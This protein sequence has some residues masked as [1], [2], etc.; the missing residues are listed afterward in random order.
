[1]TK[2]EVELLFWKGKQY[3]KFLLI[4][5]QDIRAGFCALIVYALNGIRK[6]E[7]INAIPIIDFNGNNTAEYYEE[8]VGTSIWDYFFESTVPF[9]PAQIKARLKNGELSKYAV[10][11]IPANEFGFAHHHDPNRIATFWSWQEP[12]DRANWMREKRQLGRL[13][14]QKYVHPKE[15]ITALVDHFVQANF[16]GSFIIGL[17]IRGTDFDYAKPITID[18]YNNEI[19]RLVRKHNSENYKIY[20]A[21]DQQQY[22]NQF[23]ERYGKK[24]IFFEVTRSSSHIA[25][26]RLAGVSGYR[27][28]ED[29][30]IDILLLSRCRHIIKG[31]AALGEMGLW[32]CDHNNITDFAVQSKFYEKRY[33][34][35]RSAFSALNIGQISHGQLK[36]QAFKEGVIKHLLALKIIKLMFGKFERVRRWL[37]C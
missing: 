33:S 20:V 31:P 11:T 32:F 4:E 19:D 34:Q 3:D 14:V 12:I 21:T 13:Y 30:L 18:K 23:T 16:N 10:A 2:N 8:S 28:G 29:A 5:N 15:H 36:K 6:A 27:K 26:F 24:V 22:L 25:P 35:L 17:H 37:K 7:A 1:M 9:T